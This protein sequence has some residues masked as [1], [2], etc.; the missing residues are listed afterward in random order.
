MRRFVRPALALSLLV[1]L[2]TAG[3]AGVAQ[4]KFSSFLS[5]SIN[6]RLEIV[7]AT[8]ARDFGA[9]IDLGLSLDEVANGQAI[10]DRARKHDPSIEAVYVID[11]DGKVLHVGGTAPSAI[12][13]ETLESFD[14]ALKGVTGPDWGTE[15]D[16]VLRSGSLIQGS[17]R[18]PVGA[19][20]VEYPTT[21]MRGQT[22]SMAGRL[23]INGLVVAAGLAVFGAVVLGAFRSRLARVGSEGSVDNADLS[24][25]GL[26]DPES[27][28]AT[29][30][31]SRLLAVSISLLLLVGVTVFGVLIVREFNN[32]LAP[33]LERRAALIG[34]TISDDTERAVAVGIPIDELVGVGEYFDVFLNEF[35][36]LDYLAIQDD[37][38]QILYAAGTAGPDGD[39]LLGTS[40]AT[41]Y[42]FSVRNESREVGTVVV[43]VDSGFVRSRLQDLALDVVVILIVALVIAFEVTLVLSRRIATRSVQLPAEGHSAA[44]SGA[45]DIRIVLFLFVVG[46]ELNKSFLP[47]L[48]QGAD[49]PIPGLDPNVAISL[50]IVA[51]LLT[52]AVASPIAGRL[53]D[54]FGDRG[55]FAIGVVP[56]ALSHLG[57]VFADNVIQIIGWRSL[58]GVGYALATIAAMEYVLDRIPSDKR[59]KGIGVFIAV[60]IGGTFA[61]TAL[62][63]ILADRLGYDVVFMI[64]LGLVMLAGVLGLRVMRQRTPMK[65]DGAEPF[66]M[67]DIV[68]V[69]KQ[70]SL[71]LLM[72]GVTIPM[73]VLMAA[74]LW[75]LVPLTMASVGSSASEIARA[76]MVYYLVIL[77]G[78][79]LVTKVAERRVGN[80]VLVG[81][82]SVVSGAVLL[83]PALSPS[84]LTVSL[85]VLVAGIGHAAVRGPQI[86][87]AL[88]IA[89]TE[90]PEGGRGPILGAMRS[91]ERLGSLAGLLFAAM[92]AARFD[93]TVAIGAIG[94]AGAVAGLIYLVA[95][96]LVRSKEVA[97]A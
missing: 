48:I 77:L 24:S 8:S 87:L 85:A 60:I 20:V 28:S 56:A 86:A 27:D 6:R 33:E 65:G 41:G 22:R 94:V 84:A 53:I 73:N 31:T 45:G 43:G 44:R 78:G 13:G 47:L 69:L 1:V 36:E 39:T 92:L 57:M 35:P 25:G 11:L 83:L 95:R 40:G 62:G 81:V 34:E 12:D 51:Y 9:A 29:E 23:A 10:L 38:G 72:A 79:P 2:L 14:L 63:G 64:S 70:P 91:L 46:E 75:Y 58:T 15:S 93:L 30:R 68:V 32:A 90:F 55:L 80:W 4:L 21:E 16:E 7:A 66:S 3:L 42:G 82:G 17:F 67:R 88:D 97:D 18:Q 61:G 49:N 5:E 96:P 71:V 54:R 59:A 76:L 19:I 74:F 52:I 26:L 89:D 50:P 37:Q